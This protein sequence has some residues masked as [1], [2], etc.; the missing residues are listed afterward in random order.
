MLNCFLLT[1]SF[2]SKFS[3]NKKKKKK[4]KILFTLA[5]TYFEHVFYSL[6]LEKK[7]LIKN[8]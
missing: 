6:N 3:N 5:E 7:L 1:I 2:I 8:L 4:P